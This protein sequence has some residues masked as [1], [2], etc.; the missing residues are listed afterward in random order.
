MKTGLYLFGLSTCQLMSWGRGGG[1]KV[2]NEKG[3]LITM[4]SRSP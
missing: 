1:F 3:K 2:Q 4:R